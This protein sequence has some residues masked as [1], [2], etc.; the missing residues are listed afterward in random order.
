MS[1]L[2]N[3][4]MTRREWVSGLYSSEREMTARW[5]HE[6]DSRSGRLVETDVSRTVSVVVSVAGDPGVESA[7][8]L[9]VVV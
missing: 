6:A 8:R 2:K 3:E 1:D 4:R 9:G 7:E 5:T